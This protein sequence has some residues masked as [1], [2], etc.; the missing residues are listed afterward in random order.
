M[1]RYNMFDIKYLLTIELR[2]VL[3]GL[4]QRYEVLTSGLQTVSKICSLFRS[5]ALQ[6]DITR[7]CTGDSLYVLPELTRSLLL[8]YSEN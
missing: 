5:I 8:L 1:Y 6:T 4:Q 2:R 7:T 3:L